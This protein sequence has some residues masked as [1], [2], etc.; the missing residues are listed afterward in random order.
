MDHR[1]SRAWAAVVSLALAQLEP[2]PALAVRAWALISS[3][4]LPRYSHGSTGLAHTVTGPSK[5]PPSPSAIRELPPATT[6]NAIPLAREPPHALKQRRRDELVQV[7]PC[8]KCLHLLRGVPAGTGPRLNLGGR[9]LLCGEK[10]TSTLRAGKEI[11]GNGPRRGRT[12]AY[13]AWQR[14]IARIMARRN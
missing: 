9:R 4:Y 8:R 5:Q 14:A 13:S 11:T 1:S 3:R 7:L 10:E 12:H 2:G 6:A